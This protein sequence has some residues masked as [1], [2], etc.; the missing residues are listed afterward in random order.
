MNTFIEFYNPPHTQLLSPT[1]NRNED[2]P[3]SVGKERTFLITWQIGTRCGQ[4]EVYRYI[5][6]NETIENENLIGIAHVQTR[7]SAD[8]HRFTVVYF[9]ERRAL[10][11]RNFQV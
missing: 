11:I 7:D 8:F 5:R 1:A 4:L 9:D 10:S 2:N 3:Y 6:Y